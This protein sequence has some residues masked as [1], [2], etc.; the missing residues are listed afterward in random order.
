VYSI[1]DLEL[2]GACRERKD[3]TLDPE[4]YGLPKYPSDFVNSIGKRGS[5]VSSP[6]LIE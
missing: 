5:N 1:E 6:I 4:K 3:P 2:L